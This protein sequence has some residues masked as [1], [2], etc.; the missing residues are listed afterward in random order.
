[1][2]V[3]LIKLLQ[4]MS[5]EEFKQL[6]EQTLIDGDNSASIHRIYS[7]INNKSKECENLVY[8]FYKNNNDGLSLASIGSCY[9]FGYGVTQD[10]TKAKFY[11]E[12]A[13]EK[14]DSYGFNGLGYLYRNGRSVTLDY[15][16]AKFYYEKAVEK[17]NPYGYS[18]LGALYQLGH[19]VTLDY[20]RAK[21]YY[22]L[23]AE[24]GNP[25]GYNNLGFLY[26]NGYGVTKD[27]TK[28]KFYYELAAEKNSSHGYNNL[29]SLYYHGYGVTLDYTK[30]KFYYEKA[31]EKGNPSGF[32][33]LGLIY[34]EEKNR[35]KM[36]I[37]Y[38]KAYS[39]NND[40]AIT[41]INESPW[42]LNLG[43]ALLKVEELEIRIR[44]RDKLALQEAGVGRRDLISAL[45]QQFL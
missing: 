16:K 41:K 18:S 11:Y 19:G 24:K 15:A 40:S 42:I 39:L 13:A 34:E 21:F 26:R 45:V 22:K 4:T 35:N 17:D 43:E 32:Y 7:I 8:N 36:A 44:L 23:A 14:D 25:S 29:G 31:I 38:V 2:K 28:A 5:D 27:Y 3:L 6:L 33:N 10:Y 1:M 20:S 37:N 30:A 12:L 9:C